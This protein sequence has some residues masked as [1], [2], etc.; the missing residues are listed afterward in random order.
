MYQ[1]YF[2]LEWHS[3]CFGRSFRP[4]SGVRDCTY[5]NRHLSNRYCCLL[6][7]G[8]DMSSELISNL[9]ASRKQYLF[10]K[11]LLLY[12][13]SRTPDDGR[14]DRPKHVECHSEIKY[15]WYI[16]ASS[17]FYYRNNITMHGP[18]NVKYVYVSY[19]HIVCGLFR[20]GSWF[21]RTVDLVL[22]TCVYVKLVYLFYSGL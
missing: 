4:S 3:T 15:M 18:M 7:S 20:S 9:L 6:A 5:S 1:I 8:F 11:C 2:T 14:T 10:D 12:L 17:W 21:L 19:Q 16:G 13:Q 22:C